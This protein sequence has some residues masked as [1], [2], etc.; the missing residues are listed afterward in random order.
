MLIVYCQPLI[1]AGFIINYTKE[2]LLIVHWNAALIAE[3]CFNACVTLQQRIKQF[4][5][6][7]SSFIESQV[8]I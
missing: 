8:R 6:D 1:K 3:I 4:L 2:F 7:F 5:P